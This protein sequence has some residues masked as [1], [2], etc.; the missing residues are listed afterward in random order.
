MHLEMAHWNNIHPSIQMKAVNKYK[1]AL[2]SVL[3]HA[4]G[5]IV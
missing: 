5:L 2:V 1:Y 3:P 4:D